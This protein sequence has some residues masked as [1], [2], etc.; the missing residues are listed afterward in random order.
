M[1]GVL[2]SPHQE[3]KLGAAAAAAGTSKKESK[4]QESKEVNTTA[5]ENSITRHHQTC[6]L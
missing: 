5:N 4:K 1:D 2:F 3:C 6:N